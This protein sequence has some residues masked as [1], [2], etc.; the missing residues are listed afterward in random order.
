MLIHK[1]ST[2]FGSGTKM[3]ADE[4]EDYREFSNMLREDIL[5]ILAERATISRD[6]VARKWDRK[7][8]WLSA[9]EAVELGFADRVE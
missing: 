5:D 4:M 1:G 9:Q 6:E 8:W 3:T 2:Q 7:D